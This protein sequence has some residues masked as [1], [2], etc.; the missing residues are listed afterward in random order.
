MQ[1]LPQKP[2]NKGAGA[3]PLHSLKGCHALCTLPRPSYY[4]TQKRLL[5]HSPP[6]AGILAWRG[7]PHPCVFVRVC[8]L[9]QLYLAI[10]LFKDLLVFIGTSGVQREGETEKDVPSA[11]SLPKCPQ[12]PELSSSKA[13]SQE[14]LLG[15]PHECRVPR[16]WAIL[17]CFLR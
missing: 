6:L 1:L 10:P 11:G 2:N 5:P 16:L 15:L 7:N 3:P 8:S 12:W 17:D 13:N 14:L 4:S 9:S